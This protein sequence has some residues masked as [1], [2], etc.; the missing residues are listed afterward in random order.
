MR[1]FLRI[2]AGSLVLHAAAG[3]QYL[4][5][6]V[7]VAVTIR[8]AE[9]KAPVAG[10]QVAILYPTDESGVH[11]RD[12]SGVTSATGVVHVQASTDD[13]ALPQVKINAANYIEDQRMLPGD[14]LR[15]I[16]STSPLGPLFGR[17]EPV[18]VALEVYRGPMPVIDLI[19]PNGY[20]G[21]VKVEIRIRE[22]VAYEQGQRV[23]RYNVP[24]DGSV[25][26]DGP[27]ILRNIRKP[28]YFAR[29]PDDTQ[30]PTDVKDNEVGFR[31]LRAEGRTEVFV[32]GTKAEWENF[33]RA[34]DKNSN[35]DSG[36]SKKGSRRGGG[37]S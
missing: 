3:C 16:R 18:E 21:L 10:A 12:V 37:G 8:D 19:V 1:L 28:V 36:S 22:D 20:R 31:W 34:G 35:S 7:P 24:P 23:F 2:I 6:T 4:H 29:Y 14:A 5:P 17:N 30:V 32:I 9:T 13:E 27:P 26:A 11:G 33:R 15:A 25:Q